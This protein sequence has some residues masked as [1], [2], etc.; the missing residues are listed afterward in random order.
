MLYLGV[1]LL[2]AVYV[3]S[4]GVLACVSLNL[5]VVRREDGGYKASDFNLKLPRVRFYLRSAEAKKSILKPSAAGFFAGTT[6]MNVLLD[7]IIFLFK[8]Y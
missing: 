3:Y 1:N 2:S 4:L 7:N 6:F 8:Y 5:G